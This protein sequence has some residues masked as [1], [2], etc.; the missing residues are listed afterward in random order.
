MLIV[1][2]AAP[3]GATY[4]PL[5]RSWNDKKTSYSINISC[6]T[7]RGK[8]PQCPFTQNSFTH[9]RHPRYPNYGCENWRSRLGEPAP[10]FCE[11]VPH[12][13]EPAPH[14]G[15]P[16]PY[17]DKPAPE[18]SKPTPRFGKLAPHFGKPAPQFCKRAPTIRR[19]PLSSC[20]ELC[21]SLGI[22]PGSFAVDI[23]CL[24]HEELRS[25]VWTDGVEAF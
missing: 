25:D 5:L 20:Y 14:F 10:H 17:F 7:A 21:G 15:E 2:N 3:L 1:Q 12:F 23:S 9:G 8:G 4:I 24:R 11:P 19:P 22:E 13:S 16:A 18:F 6:L